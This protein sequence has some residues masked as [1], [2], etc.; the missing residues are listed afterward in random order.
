MDKHQSID[1][2]AEK[3]AQE[4]INYNFCSSLNLQNIKDKL[5]SMLNHI[6]DNGMFAEY[7]MHD[8]SH[9][10]G[11][12]SLLE[13]I[14]PTRTM[15]EMTPA[16]WLMTVLAIYFHDLGMLIPQGEYDNRTSDSEYLKTKDEMLRNPETKAYVESI[17][18][19]KGEK[20]LF[21]E[22]VRKNHGKRICEW[23]TNC[24]QKVQEPYKM[25]SDMLSG[26]DLSFRTDLAL[27][28]KSH[29]QDDLPEHLK[30]VDEAYGSTDKEKVNLLYASVLLRSADILHMTHDRTPDVE[31]R[32]ISPQ[33]KISIVEWAKQRAVR[34]VDVHKERDENG[35]INNSIQPHRFEIQAKFTDDKGYF[36][37]KSFIDYAISELKRCHQWCEESRISNSNNYL[38]PWSDI[39]TSRVLAEGFEKSKLKFEI[40]QKNILRLLTGHTLYNDSTVVIRELVQ[41][42]M[43][44]GKLQDHNGKTGSTY[45]SK[46]EIRWDSA[47][48]I[49]RVADNATGMDTEAIKNFLLKVGASKYQ[50]ESFKKEFPDFHSISRF[51]IG[52]LTCF[53]ISDDVD[54]YTLDEKENQCHLL[55]IRNLNGEYLMRN[56]ADTSHILGG[57]HGTT[58]ELKVRPEIQMDDIEMQI[59]QWIVIPFSDVTL[60]I[61][62]GVPIKIGYTQVKEAVEDFASRLN[63]VDLS[64]GRYRVAQ[65]SRDGIE[66]AF[67][68][69]LNTTMKVWTL[70]QY[71]ESEVIEEAPIGICVEGIKVISETPGLHGRIN[72]VLANCT[73]KNAPTTNVARNDLEGGKLLE[74]M[75]RAIYEMYI[76]SF[77]SQFTDLQ[78]AYNLTWA[79][80]EINYLL[81]GFYHF[82]PYSRFERRDILCDVLKKAECNP[83]DDGKV[84]KLI[85]IVDLPEKITTLDSRAFT[86]A[87][88]LLKDINKTDKTAL[89]LLTDLEKSSS[90]TDTILMSDVMASCNYDLFLEEYEVESVHADESTRRIKF[91][92][93]RNSG[94]WKH[95]HLQLGRGSNHLFILLKNNEIEVEGMDDKRSIVSGNCVFLINDS[96]LLT[97]LRDLILNKNIS[98]DALE[99]VSNLVGQIIFDR[100]VQDEQTIDRYMKSEANYLKKAIYDYFTLDQLKEALKGCKDTVLNIK[101]YY[102]YY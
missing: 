78:S 32:I 100:E 9:V 96:P 101:K 29:Q 83:I 42:A 40:D 45:K 58:F 57:E 72:L 63:G 49:L 89:G 94:I 7:T 31:F 13:K 28:C 69:K 1:S 8:I 48:R 82:R 87:V 88:S 47:N 84:L 3:K 64:S 4:C 55:K 27:V 15:D 17:Q 22:Y 39:D 6:G 52:L 62:G 10:D 5:A 30:S 34:I 16:D 51:G 19:D 70:Y 60:S 24:D 99:I 92:W 59:R 61:D 102:R 77:T 23:I 50:S 80:S 95:V 68:Q 75:Y 79:T 91:T 90:E 56:D 12:L 43:D 11:M 25:I 33:N 46:V 35:N 26:V 71:Q 38:F 44:A 86:A 74:N 18:D 97:F 67:L 85:S 66:V 93:K 76:E 73:G 54:I 14:I 37:F 65:Y 21:Q 20:F 41:N 81:D 53:M 36:S 2:F 98:G